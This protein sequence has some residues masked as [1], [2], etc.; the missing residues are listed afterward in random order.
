MA[1]IS[2]PTV[3]VVTIPSRMLGVY[4]NAVLDGIAGDPKLIS[5]RQ[6][7]PGTFIVLA[8]R[9]NI[10]SSHRF[11][12]WLVGWYGAVE[13]HFFSDFEDAKEDFN[14]R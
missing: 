5:S 12:T 8:E 9:T 13:G 1:T 10:G 3:D 6:T 7:K 4:L 2:P 14:L 11:V